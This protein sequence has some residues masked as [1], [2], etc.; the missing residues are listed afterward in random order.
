MKY[1]GTGGEF[2]SGFTRFP[3]PRVHAINHESISVVSRGARAFK[4]VVR[5]VMNCSW[6]VRNSDVSL[7]DA[8]FPSFRAIPRHVFV[9]GFV[10]DSVRT[11]RFCHV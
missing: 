10:Y 5:D 2:L 1:S 6:V 7:N 3:F 11:N 8:S 4:I 9:S